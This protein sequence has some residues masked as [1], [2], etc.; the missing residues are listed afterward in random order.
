[1]SNRRREPIPQPPRKPTLL[2]ATIT[3]HAPQGDVVMTWD[4]A[5]G[6]VTYDGEGIGNTNNLA[7]LHSVAKGIAVTLKK[8]QQES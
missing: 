3:F 7:E 1:M 4:A 8:P 5:N 2:N 6:D